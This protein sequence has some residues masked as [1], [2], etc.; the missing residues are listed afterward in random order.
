MG[1]FPLLD[2]GIGLILIY[3][4]LSLLTSEIT[5]IL[6]AVLRWRAK[7][8]QQD[9]MTLFGESTK[10]RRDPEQFKNTITGRL[11]YSSLIAAMTQRSRSSRRFVG[12]SYIP[13]NLFADALLEVLQSLPNAE[14]KASQVSEDVHRST[15]EIVVLMTKVE[16]SDA[17]PA[18]LKDNLN[19]LA[20]RT[21]TRT[22]TTELQ[23]EQFRQ[24]IALWYEQSMTRLSGRYQRHVKAFTVLIGAVVAVVI[25]AD[26]LFMLRRLSENTATRSVII[27]NAMQ[28][29]GCQADLSSSHCMNEMAR[30]LESTTVPIGWHPVNFRQQFPK[31]QPYYLSRALFGWLLTGLAISM[32][33]RFWFQ[34]L[35]QFIHIEETEDKPDSTKE[36]RTEKRAN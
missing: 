11:Y 10:L 21:Q 8:L 9:I 20:K 31:L 28:I 13:S 27:Q 36:Q 29:Q 16:A 22:Q 30:L 5:Q 2:I 34:L 7:H 19:Q 35:N 26:S 14:S 17:L 24:E 32:G 1:S 23:L 15:D 6:T 18:S 3:T 33:S 25:N 4:F 12:P